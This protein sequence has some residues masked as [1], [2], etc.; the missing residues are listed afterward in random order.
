MVTKDLNNR[1][2]IEGKT[3]KQ[4]KILNLTSNQENE[5]LEQQ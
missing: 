5:K 1:Y 4:K 2:F 3:R